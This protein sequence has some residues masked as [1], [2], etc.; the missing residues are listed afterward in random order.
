MVEEATKVLEAIVDESWLPWV[1]CLIPNISC[2]FRAEAE[3]KARVEQDR[4]V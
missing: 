3:A 1:E 4:K 2:Q